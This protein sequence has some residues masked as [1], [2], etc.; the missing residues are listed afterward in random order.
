M[1]LMFT[2]ID[3]LAKF[4]PEPPDAARDWPIGK[5]FV[6]FLSAHEYGNVVR[7]NAELLWAARNSLVH[8]FNVPDDERLAK[9]GLRYAGFGRR[10][11]EETTSGPGQV[12]IERSP[13][14][15]IV[16]VDGLF[17]RTVAIIAKVQESLLGQ[18]GEVNRPAFVSAFDK[19]G[20]IKVSL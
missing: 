5:R 17:K 14:T 15:A 6:W 2:T 9:R 19:Y 3:L 10:K 20:S 11:R 4:V 1:I 12:L 7:E 16:Y 8:A 18:A 13:D